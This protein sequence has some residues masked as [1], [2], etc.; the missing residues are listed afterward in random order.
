MI[1]R[2]GNFLR[3]FGSVYEARWGP[4]VGFARAERLH[5]KHLGKSM[6]GWNDRAMAC[7]SDD[8]GLE[9][10]GVKERSACSCA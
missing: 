1:W 9:R 8:E 10:A 6:I 4:E 2:A 5:C 7:L 3:G